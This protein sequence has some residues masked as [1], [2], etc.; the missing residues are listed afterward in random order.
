MSCSTDERCSA[1]VP[2]GGRTCLLRSVVLRDGK[3]YCKI[4]DPVA[5]AASR[6]ARSAKWNAE[7]KDK[8][9]REAKQAA[10]REAEYHALAV[11]RDGFEYDHG[12]SDLDDEQP[13][14]I[15]ATLGDWRKINALLTK[16]GDKS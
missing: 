12:H 6:A 14:D 4:H 13:I 8:K 1:S 15:R 10:L 7:W 11:F 9:E 2:A 3:G 16:A 5:V